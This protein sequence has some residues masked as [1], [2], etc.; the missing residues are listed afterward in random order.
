MALEVKIVD[1]QSQ[2]AATITLKTTQA[3]IAPD[4]GQAYGTLH[5]FIQTTDSQFAGPPF[6][7]YQ[8]VSGPE[9]T[10]VVGFPVTRPIQGKGD[11]QPGETPSGKAAMTLHIGP[12]SKLMDSWNLFA[13][14]IKAQGYKMEALGWES[15]VDDPDTTPESDLKTELYWAI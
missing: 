9:W 10:V 6:A 14:W 4:M 5:T 1:V 13:E 15:Y 11:I 2:P 7:L 8:D 12:Y 3:T